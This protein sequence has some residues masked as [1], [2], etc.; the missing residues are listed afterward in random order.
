M[1]HGGIR[2]GAPLGSGRR[3]TPWRTPGGPG[4]VAVAV[5]LAVLP[6]TAGEVDGLLRVNVEHQQ[7]AGVET[8]AWRTTLDARWNRPVNDVFS[9]LAS[10]RF[11]TGATEQLFGMDPLR[12]VD[13]TEVEPRLELSLAPEWFDLDLG[14]RWLRKSGSTLGVDTDVDENNLF[15]RLETRSTDVPRLSLDYDRRD[16]ALDVSDLFVAS[17]Q[18]LERIGYEIAFDRPTWRVSAGRR[19]SV[20]ESDDDRRT[21]TDTLLTASIN[22]RSGSGR[23]TL[24]AQANVNDNETRQTVPGQ[25]LVAI[26]RAV[27]RGLSALD[28]LPATDPL[29]D[30]PALVDGDRSTPT[31]INI[32]GALAGGSIDWNAGVE[33]TLDE[34]VDVIDLWITPAIPLQNASVYQWEVYES[35][36]NFT[37]DLVTPLATALYDPLDGRFRLVFPTVTARYVKVVNTTIDDTLGAVRV[38]EL[39]PFG[40]ELRSG[41][42]VQ[43]TRS[44]NVSATVTWAPGP[45]LFARL[46]GSHRRLDSDDPLGPTDELANSDGRLTL[47]FT[48]SSVFSALATASV[49]RRQSTN[50][51][52]QNDLTIGLTLTAVPVPDLTLTLAS[53]RRDQER[54]LQSATSIGYVMRA[55]ALLYRGLS[56]SAEYGRS[57]DENLDS[58]LRNRETVEFRV[59]TTPREGLE[60]NSSYRRERLEMP[61]LT[62]PERDQR[63]VTWA[64]QLLIRP[65]SLLSLSLQAIRFDFLDREGWSTVYQVDWSPLRGGTVQF[66]LLYRDEDPLSEVERTLRSLRLRWSIGRRSFVELSADRQRTESPQFGVV[67]TSIGRVFFQSRF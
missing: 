62:G 63:N 5:A 46:N 17:D 45:H 11:T 38:T 58:R 50:L 41:T 12:E 65:S 1:R 26:P 4:V 49:G 13:D 47:G 6:A 40:Q 60:L 64:N 29:Q 51:D 44:E 8:D 39:E 42:T 32:G 34:S 14:G 43:T 57:Q 52:D 19:R 10:L 20:Q 66:T 37:W 16:R 67:A 48:P 54:G 7:G 53:S 55:A 59:D 24:F 30:T 9:Y 36:D 35:Q 31:A 23:M 33:L 15:A 18:L 28:V 21:V 27:T 25:T 22:R 2:D 56:C 3:S 61:S